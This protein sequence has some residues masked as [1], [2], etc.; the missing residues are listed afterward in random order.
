MFHMFLAFFRLFFILLFTALIVL[1]ILIV[2]P[3]STSMMLK[4]MKLWGKLLTW[5]FGLHLEIKG[6]VPKDDG[7]LIA[8]HRSYMDIPL[9]MGFKACVFLAKAELEKAPVIGWAGRHAESIFVKRD[10][11]ESRKHAREALVDR[12]KKGFSVMVFAEGTTTAQYEL[13]PLKL[14]MFQTAIE[15]QFPLTPILIEFK[16]AR[17]PWFGDADAGKHFIK[18]VGI[19]R[20]DA[21]LIFGPTLKA[22]ISQEN[23]NRS[24]EEITEM[25]IKLKDEVET[26]MLNEISEIKRKNLK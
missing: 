24:H 18:N 19:W 4:L 22:H 26:W 12:L 20:N 21:I 1:V 15:G 25:A 8:N 16:E 9:I 23:R 7:I 13:L 3:F 14:G 6:D 2:K 5:C 17:L 11:P 10:S